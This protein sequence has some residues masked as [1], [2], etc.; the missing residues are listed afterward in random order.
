M[1]LASRFRSLNTQKVKKF[2]LLIP[3]LV[4]VAGSVLA[5]E[6]ELP[7]PSSKPKSETPPANTN[8]NSPDPGTFQ[9]FSKPKKVDFSKFIIEPD[10]TFNIGQGRIDVGVS[11]LVGYNVWKGLCVGGGFVYLYTGFNGLQITS[12]SGAVVGTAKASYQTYGPA[13]L[14]QYNIWKGLF[15]RAK[16][17][18]L[19]RDMSDLNA[20]PIQNPNNPSDYYFPRIR[21]AIPDLLIGAGYNLLRSKNIF[22]PIIVSYNVLTS[23][24]NKTYT[25]YP[26]GVVIQL[27]FVQVF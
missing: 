24:T 27:G 20:Q 14:L 19:E 2:L 5:Q 21:L 10:F 22:V 13:F 26:N 4:F 15:A 7:P 16:F 23:V 18:V 8:T 12:G 11:P 6:D 3:M 1:Y 17:E 25:I 9:G